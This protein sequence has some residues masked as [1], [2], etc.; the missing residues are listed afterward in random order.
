MASDQRKVWTA[1]AD[2]FDR[3]RQKP[4]PHVAAFIGDLPSASVVL[5]LMSGNGRHARAAAEAAHHPVALDWSLPLLR[6]AHGDKVLADAT[7]I[8]LRDGTIDAAV[9]CAGLHGLPTAA[10]RAA[11]LEELRRVLRPGGAAQVTVWSRNAPRFTA[12]GLPPGP[13]DVVV[14]WRSGSREEQRRYHLYTAESLRDA[15]EA[16]GFGVESL[17]AVSIAEPDDNLVALARR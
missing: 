2:A 15:L 14:P 17:K 13:A 7:R 3:T 16:A 12:M 4:W 8:P 11:S 10:G 9:Y 1:I 5:D 6:R